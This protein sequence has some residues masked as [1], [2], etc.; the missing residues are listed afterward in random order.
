[1]ILSDI[2]LPAMAVGAAIIALA[3]AVLV[4]VRLLDRDR[5]LGEVDA[6]GRALSLVAWVAILLLLLMLV[7]VCSGLL[8]A[9]IAVGCVVVVAWRVHRA[10]QYSLIAALAVSAKGSAPRSASNLLRANA[11]WRCSSATAAFST[12]R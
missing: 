12:T 8:F 9:P 3:A 6:I 1:M 5:Q 11:R 10:R 7:S 4:A 2:V